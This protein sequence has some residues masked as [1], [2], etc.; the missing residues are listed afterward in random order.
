[1]TKLR[2]SN[3][4]GHRFREEPQ[5]KA[6]VTVLSKWVSSG[7][8]TVKEPSVLGWRRIGFEGLDERIFSSTAVRRQIRARSIAGRA[9]EAMS[10]EKKVE[11]PVTRRGLEK[12]GSSLT[13]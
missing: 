7:D 1:M 5:R 8:W 6:D 11:E 9:K 12:A 4:H 13:A 2:T 10:Q 3:R